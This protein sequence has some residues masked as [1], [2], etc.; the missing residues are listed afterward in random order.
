[1]ADNNNIQ[2]KHHCSFCGRGEGEVELL[3]PSP[4]G[5][6]ICNDCVEVCTEI[7]DD[8]MPAEQPE[9]DGSLSLSFDS[10]PKPSELKEKLDEYV[11]GQNEAKRVLC[12]AVY[13][14]YKRILYREEKQKKQ[15]KE[16][17]R[18]GKCNSHRG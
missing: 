4:E 8:Y 18:T 3:I 10:L 7:L 12:V 16:K 14:H 11:I 15:I 17:R 2:N 9:G 6:F 5:V 1:L 13:N